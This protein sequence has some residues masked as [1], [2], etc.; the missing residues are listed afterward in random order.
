[1]RAVLDANVLVSAV[2]GSVGAPVSLRAEWKAGTFELVVSE[3]LLAELAATLGRPK[4]RRRVP[5]PDA[6][7][8]VQ[9]LRDRALV[10]PDPA[11]PAKRCADP[12][13]D[14]LIALAEGANAYLVSGDRHLLALRDELPIASPREFLERLRESLP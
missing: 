10:V 11:E 7:D 6:V 14:Y 5:E 2:L 8:L 9:L 4:L 3:A 12:D 1:V 13:D